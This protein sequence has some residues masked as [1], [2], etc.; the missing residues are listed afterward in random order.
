MLAVLAHEDPADDRP[1]QAQAAHVRRQV[2]EAHTRIGPG[3]GR[4]DGRG[5]GDQAD[6]ARPGAAQ[7]DPLGRAQRALT[8]PDSSWVMLGV[9]RMTTMWR[10]VGGSARHA[11]R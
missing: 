9:S 11:A 8:Q 7:A 4:C 10:T 5:I 6:G 1:A 3:E 2:D